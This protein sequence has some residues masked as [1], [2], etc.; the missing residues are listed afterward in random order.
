MLYWAGGLLACGVVFGVL[1][2][3]F[4]AAVLERCLLFAD[5]AFRCSGF[6]AAPRSQQCQEVL[7]LFFA[8]SRAQC[9]PF[10]PQSV[11][12]CEEPPLPK[13]GR[14]SAYVSEGR[15]LRGLVTPSFRTAFVRHNLSEIEATKTLR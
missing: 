5:T 11:V 4:I 6:F 8:L 12:D 2:R 14:G 13:I 1:H 9:V 3:P 15:L 10:A 7:L